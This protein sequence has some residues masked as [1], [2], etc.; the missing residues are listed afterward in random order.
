MYVGKI[1]EIADRDRLYDNPLHPY[2]QALLSA[3]PIPD[4]DVER[5]R[6]RIILTGDIPSPV[7]PPS[8]CRFHTRCPIAFDRC[9]VEVPAFKVYEPGI[10]PRAT[11]SKS[12]AARRRISPPAR[13]VDAVK[14]TRSGPCD[15][16]SLMF[17]KR[18]SATSSCAR[19]LSSCVRRRL[20]CAA[21]SWRLSSCARRQL[22]CVRPRPSC[23]RRL[24]SCARR[25]FLRPPAAFLRPPAFFLRPPAAFL[26]RRGFLL[27]TAGGFLTPPAA[28]LRHRRP[29]YGRL[30]LLAAA[31]AAVFFGRWRL[32]CGSLLAAAPLRRPPA[33]PVQPLL[34]RRHR[35]RSSYSESIQP[36][37]PRGRVVVTH[38]ASTNRRRIVTSQHTQE[39][40]I[41]ATLRARRA[42]RARA[43]A[44]RHFGPA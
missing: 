44:R 24:S 3:I 22:S 1:V 17:R 39:F 2:T 11:G 33:S 9:K 12:T 41:R 43:R 40:A 8:G 36:P 4:P 30:R 23:A 19:R 16:S 28:F 38:D 25:R 32:S 34:R 10:A 18:R 6:K 13:L 26:R 21:P 42:V 20:S 37:R 7:N 14:K 35:R 5:R 27:A 29:S 31:F 15:R